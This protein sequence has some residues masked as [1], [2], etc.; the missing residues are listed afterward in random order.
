MTAIRLVTRADDLGSFSGAAAAAID[1]HRHGIIQNTGVMV[2]TPWFPDA[3]ARLKEAP[4]LCVGVHLTICCEWGRNRWRPILPAQQVP[5]L[6]GADGYLHKDPVAM[7]HAGIKPAEI[8]AECQ[9]QLDRA[10]AYG[11]D[12]IY[13]DTHMGWEWMHPLPNG[14][15]LSELMPAWC[16]ANGV[17]WTARLPAAGLPRAASGA[18]T[19]RGRLLASLDVAT[20]GTYLFVIHPSLH[21]TVINQEAIGHAPGAV[22][23]ERVGDWQVGRSAQLKAELAR[24]GVRTVRWDE[25]AA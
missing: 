13:A 10:R 11:L 19:L 9:A 20:P 2:P 18:Q 5:S 6:V 25:L 15:R 22:A 21:G 17:L 1:A 12:I 23:G 24:R 16:R 4:S 14:T 8:L 3:V 7:H